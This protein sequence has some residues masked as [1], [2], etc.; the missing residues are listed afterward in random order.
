MLNVTATFVASALN[1]LRSAVNWTESNFSSTINS[2][3]LV[4]NINSILYINYSLFVYFLLT[5][6]QQSSLGG[7]TGMVQVCHNEGSELV[8]R[9]E[10]V[11]YGVGEGEAGVRTNNER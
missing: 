2:P 8:T 1:L 11:D 9:D 6:H 3:K 5:P 7:L 10:R 4:I